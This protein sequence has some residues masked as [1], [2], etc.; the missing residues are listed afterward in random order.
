[1]NELKYTSRDFK[2]IKTDLLDAINAVTSNWTSRED[3]DPGIVLVNLMSYLGD[4][5]S[6]NLDMQAQEMYLPTVTQRKNIKKILELLGYKLHWYRSGIVSVS[7]NNNSSNTIVI[8]TNITSSSPNNRLATTVGNISYVILPTTNFYDTNLIEIPG[9]SSKTFTAVQGVANFVDI[10]LD[11]IGTNDNRFYIPNNNVD[12]AHL[13]LYFVKSS[14]NNNNN[15]STETEPAAIPGNYD[16]WTQVDDLNLQ[17]DTG[18]YFEFKTDDYDRPYIQLPNYWR[19]LTGAGGTGNTYTFKLYYILSNGADGNVSDNAFYTIYNTPVTTS[20]ESITAS[21]IT[22]SNYTNQNSNSDGN[23]PGYNPQTVDEAR[24]DAKN[25]IN[26]FDTLVTINDFEKFVKRQVK[27]NAAIAIDVQ[28]AK[29]LNTNI[30]NN[31]LPR[32]TNTIIDKNLNAYR[33]QKYVCK[34][35]NMPIVVTTDNDSLDVSTYD[36]YRTITESDLNSDTGYLNTNIPASILKEEGIQNYKLNIYCI[37]DNYNTDFIGLTNI[38]EWNSPIN[39]NVID[40]NSSS[41]FNSV[42]PYRRYKISDDVIYGSTSINGIYEKL[43]DTK[44]MNVDVEF[45]TC[46]VFD[47]RA[48]GTIYLRNPVVEDEAESIIENVVNA[49]ANKFTPDYVG[50]GQKIPYIDVIETIQNADSRI[51]YF[52]AGRGDKK[53][54]DW[55]I[56]AFDVDGYFNPISIM[57]FNQYS[58]PNNYTF[59]L[60]TGDILVPQFNEDEDGN[61]LLVIDSSCILNN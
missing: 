4:N 5:L 53:L 27:F 52:D 41:D 38:D 56:Q 50:F 10:N 51:R 15:N 39:P 43:Q 23:C 46:R 33:I 57:R 34:E 31:N 20:G 37:Y 17:T 26:T 14:N 12:E 6:F 45:A 22:I 21:D 49:L 48:V 36:D 3:T 16:L 25:Y 59:G 47:W 60:G 44:I 30:Y 24:A 58:V 2:S 8:N 32:P 29:D 18:K 9:H 28:R 54:V 11:S 13:Y 42:Y 35:G 7:I 55:S 19:A 40:L 1:M 61:P